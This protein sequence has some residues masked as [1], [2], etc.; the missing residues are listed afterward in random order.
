MK[1]SIDGMTVQ[2]KGTTSAPG[3]TVVGIDIGGT[4]THLRLKAPSGE[5]DMVIPSNDWRKRDWLLDAQAVADMVS[6]IAEGE[7]VAAVGIGAHGCDDKAECEAFEAAIKSV[8]PWP[9]HVVNDAELMPAAFG[10][11]HQ[12]GVVAGTGSIA[13]C[14]SPEDEMLVAGGWGWIIGDEGSAASL[15]R[16]A[17]RAVALHLDL[18]GTLNDPLIALLFEALEI[19]APARI[20]SR[21]AALGTARE[22]G[23]HARLVFDAADAGSVLA[24]GVIHAGGRALADFIRRLKLRGSTATSA[25]AGGSVIVSQ[26]RLWDAFQMG[27]TEI[28]GNDFSVCLHNGPPVEGAIVLAD[29]LSDGHIRTSSASTPEKALK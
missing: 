3:R 26:P 4:K 22:V 12:I 16:D 23:Q 6:R 19:P 2:I 17:A 10:L 5:R 21:L 18:G 15:V 8:A 9:V 13:V 1:A 11:D 28:V 27:V 29:R 14:R 7:L 25:V 20:G 24:D